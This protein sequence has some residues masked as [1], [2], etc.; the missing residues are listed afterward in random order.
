[1]DARIVIVMQAEAVVA[2]MAEVEVVVTG[3]TRL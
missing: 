1:M 2:S 3:K